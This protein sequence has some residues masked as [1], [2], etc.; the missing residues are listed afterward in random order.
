M[1]S[2]KTGLMCMVAPQALDLS[3]LLRPARAQG[4]ASSTRRR[5]AYKKWISQHLDPQD[6]VS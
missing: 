6:K 4:R 1:T 5:H 3:L 2:C